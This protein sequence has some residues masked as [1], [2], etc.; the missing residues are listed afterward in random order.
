[1]RLFIYDEDTDSRK[2]LEQH[3]NKLD[4]VQSITA[5]MFNSKSE[6]DS[7]IIDTLG[8]NGSLTVEVKEEDYDKWRIQG[9]RLMKLKYYD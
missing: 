1:M 2:P 3:W 8:K 9:V 6:E 7:A 4:L 5:K